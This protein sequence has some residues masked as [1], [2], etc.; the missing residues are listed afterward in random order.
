MT[1]AM[2]TLIA[3]DETPARERLRAMLAQES[4]IEVV[5]EAKNGSATLEAV[6]EFRPD[7]LFLDIRMPGCRGLEILR[8]LPA[9]LV[10]C[11][12]FTTTY[13]AYAVEAFS[14]RVLDYLLKPFTAERLRDAVDRAR[15]QL[16]R[17]T[18]KMSENRTEQSKDLRADRGRLERILVKLN[19]R[20]L[21][22]RTDEVEW[23]EAAA[24]YVVL[25]T[26]GGNQVVRKAL[27]ALED[28][29]PARQFFRVSRS[30]IVN[31]NQVTEIQFVAPGEHC[32]I[33]R[34]GARVPLTRGLRELQDALQT[35]F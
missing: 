10:S 11:T 7:L 23:L 21:V 32:V 34:N 28:E 25:H 27:S 24:N 26:R 18:P 33:L 29:L 5:A 14:V 15:A 2:R 17:G 31:L 13:D 22:V 19:E 4:D 35:P 3:D 6:A 8:A 20:Y 16:K 12:I 1:R 30:A 9:E